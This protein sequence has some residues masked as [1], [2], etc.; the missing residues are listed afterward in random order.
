[1]RSC[2]GRALQ[3][4][5]QGLERETLLRALSCQDDGGQRSYPWVKSRLQDT[6][7]VQKGK[8]KGAHRKW[9]ERVSI[10]GMLIHQ[11]GSTHEWIS[12]MQWDLIITMDDATREI[13]S[14]FFIEEEGTSSSFQGVHETLN[15]W[16]IQQLLQRSGES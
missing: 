4:D 2:I 8:R 12:G 9:R 14:G 15:S 1:M 10:P 3:R 13:Y 16:D 11:D 6:G 5:R 7:L